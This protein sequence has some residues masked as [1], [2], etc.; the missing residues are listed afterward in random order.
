MAAPSAEGCGCG[1]T[2]ALPDGE[3]ILSA[4]QKLNTDVKK[5][6]GFA[7]PMPFVPKKN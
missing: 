5:D 2:S 3:P 6:A 1:S 7:E 4:P